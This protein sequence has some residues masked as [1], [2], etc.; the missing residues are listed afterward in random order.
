MNR[1]I[2][3]NRSRDQGWNSPGTPWKFSTR[4]GPELSYTAPFQDVRQRL[5]EFTEEAGLSLASPR[6]L[7][8]VLVPL[9]GGSF[10]E[11]ALPYALAIAR[12][13]RATVRLV[14][15]HSQG[16]VLPSNGISATNELRLS[17]KRPWKTYLE[18]LVRR[19]AKVSSVPMIPVQLDGRD[20]VGSL[21]EEAR[22]DVDLIVMAT[23]GRGP[24]GRFWHGGIASGLM[25]RL[26]IP[27]LLVRGQQT[28][29]EFVME[30]AVRHVLLPLDGTPEAEQVTEPSTALGSLWGA[31]HTLLRVIRCTF[32]YVLGYGGPSP[33]PAHDTARAEAWDYLRRA[34][35]RLQPYSQGIRS[36]IL[37]TDESVAEAIL[38]YAQDNGADLIAMTPRT[39][40][41]FAR[42]IRGSVTDRVIRGARVPVLVLPSNLEKGQDRP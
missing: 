40:G 15:V 13:A 33:R 25:S 12:K 27:L 37:L 18:E 24:L 8:T 16:A 32:D 17:Q 14:H 7:R 41:W 36:R 30:P 42:F 4:N 28:L 19:L 20:V 31:H 9:D 34:S 2:T 11:H 5:S 26:P 23:R 6:R 3:T 29:P 21:R 22:A 38:R 1:T 10:G 35:A 39:R